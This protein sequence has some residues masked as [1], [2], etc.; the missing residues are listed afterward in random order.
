MVGLG[1]EKRLTS[2]FTLSQECSLGGVCLIGISW[3]QL[4]NVFLIETV[5]CSL[6]VP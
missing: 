1:P 6:S 3:Y 2:D 4:M 5:G